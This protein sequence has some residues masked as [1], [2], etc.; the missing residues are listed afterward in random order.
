[1]ILFLLVVLIDK[2]NNDLLKEENKN[3]ELETKEL[4]EKPKVNFF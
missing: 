2:R 1:L 4:I 3:D